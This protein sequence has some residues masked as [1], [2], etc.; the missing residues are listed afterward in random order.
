MERKARPIFDNLKEKNIKTN[1]KHLVAEPEYKYIKTNAKP[2][3]AYPKT[4]TVVT[5]L[6]LKPVLGS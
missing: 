3:I 4:K 5:K 1:S 2:I 6:I